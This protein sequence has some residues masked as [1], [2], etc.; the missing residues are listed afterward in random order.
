MKW[1]LRMLAMCAAFTQIGF[2]QTQ[3]L[4]LPIAVNGYVKPPIHYQTTLRIVNLS[5]TAADVTAE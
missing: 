1:L 3:E 5:G 4:I 2:A